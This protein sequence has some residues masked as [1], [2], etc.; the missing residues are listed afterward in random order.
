LRTVTYGPVTTRSLVKSFIFP[1]PVTA[2][3][4]EE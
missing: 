4:S 2:L 1:V 3:I